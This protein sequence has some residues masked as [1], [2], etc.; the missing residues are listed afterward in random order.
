MT[1]ILTNEEK[2][3]IVTQHIKNVDYAIYNLELSMVEEN[4]VASTDAAKI[5]SLTAQLNDTKAQKAALELE[6]G[7]LSE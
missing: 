6:L 4:S 7:K 2:V 1:S 5:T 3:T